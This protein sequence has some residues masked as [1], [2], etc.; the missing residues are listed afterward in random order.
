[1]KKKFLI[2][3][4][5]LFALCMLFAVACATD[6]AGDGTAAETYTITIDGE[7]SY[8]LKG[9]KVAFPDPK[10][11]D[12]DK[13][14]VEWQTE[15]GEPFDTETIPNGDLKL[16]S[17]WR[18]KYTYTVTFDGAAQTVKEGD[19]ANKPAD[20]DRE[21]LK[22]AGW[23]EDGVAFDPAAPICGD[24]TYL[25]RWVKE[26]EEP[27]KDL[28]K[29]AFA[30]IGPLGGTNAMQW[31]SAV[32]RDS[33]GIAF[34]FETAE[35]TMGNDG[36]A[37]FLNVGKR[38]GTSRSASTFLIRFSVAG[39]IEISYYPNNVKKTLIEGA[40]PLGNGIFAQSEKEEG[41]TTL[42]VFVPYSFFAGVDETFATSE[43]D[44]IGFT[45]TSED[46]ETGGYDVW[47]REDMPGA[48]GDAEVDRMNLADYLRVSYGGVV[49]EYDDNDADVFLS[50]NAGLPGVTV[51][52][53]GG[54]AITDEDGGWDLA[55]LSGG[56]D[57]LEI[58]YEKLAYETAV[59]RIDLVKNLVDY[60][61]GSVTLQGKVVT[62]RG[63]VKDYVSGRPV[64]GATLQYGGDGS[65]VSGPD[66]AFELQNIDISQGLT[67]KVSADN[68]GEF[69]MRYTPEQLAAEGFVMEITLV[70]RDTEFT[71]SGSVSDIRG[72]L[73]GAAVRTDGASAETLSDGT[74]TLKVG[75]GDHTVIIE[76][77][78]YVAAEI[79]VTESMLLSGTD[80]ALDLG[81]TELLMTPVQLGELGGT[82]VEYV[83]NGELTRSSEGLYFRFAT[84][85]DVPESATIGVGVFLNM[86]YP[87]YSAYRTE[88]TYLIGSYTNGKNTFAYYPG[89]SKKT[90]ELNGIVLGVSKDDNGTVLNVFIP[91]S[92]F[93]EKGI[94][95]G[96]LSDF[97]ISMTADFSSSTW[98]VWNRSDLIGVDGTEEVDRENSL[99]Y[100]IYGADNTLKEYD[101]TMTAETFEELAGSFGALQEG[102]ILFENIAAIST[103]EKTSVLP[104]AEGQQIFT[105][106]PQYKFTLPLIDAVNGMDFTYSS[107]QEGP[108]IKIEQSGY[109]ILML[110]ATGSYKS[111]RTA[112]EGDGWKMVLQGYH[113][114]GTLTDRLNYYVK[115]CEAGETYDYGKWNLYIL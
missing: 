3:L 17:V 66:G 59:S 70:S 79:E 7:T 50:G 49:Y 97:G 16:V 5:A 34:R 29:M 93:I 90:T 10:N 65:A 62:L 11:E 77:A 105:D 28:S 107:I 85:S 15:N 9:E 20:P 53:E 71:L 23:F 38:Q 109:L 12:P 115:W 47:F 21:G 113:T 8:I 108:A 22:F 100:L 27:S 37:I 95:V 80:F 111:L 40:S 106:R 14:F 46:F 13:I 86:D 63:T 54:S 83:W 61:A 114:T 24:H 68:Y 64:A 72:A 25:S 78:G 94:E 98:D 6:G 56:K 32:A 57:S 96:P 30:D 2:V 102:K 88:N 55:V 39:R 73:E 1:M 104:I 43:Y 52:C 45:L 44:V 82:R 4:S 91:Y 69:E 60:D 67:V 58:R 19:K 74:F 87:R 76:K 35:E 103:D 75:Y 36:A 89:T 33:D 101:V 18:D 112:A 51:T 92:A 41:K 48:D 31:Q 26:G 84:S 110:P 81:K 99:D 42:D